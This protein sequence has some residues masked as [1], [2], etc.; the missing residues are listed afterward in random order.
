MYVK[1]S[2]RVNFCQRV[3][4]RTSPQDDAEILQRFLHFN[5]DPKFPN[6]STDLSRAQYLVM[7]S[8]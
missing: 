2:R 8:T 3:T 6:L 1:G 4:D 7:N 5:E